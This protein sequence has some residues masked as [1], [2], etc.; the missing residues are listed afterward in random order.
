MAELLNVE[1]RETRGKRNSRRLRG[2]GK[3]PA[4]LYG[5]GKETISLSVSAEQLDAAV[6]HGARLVDLTGP[7]TQQAFIREVQWDVWG[8]HIIHADFT[9]ISSDERV[10]VEVALEIRGEAPGVR[11]GG[12]VEQPLHQ[13][14][15]EC[16]VTEIPEKLV[17]SINQL[18]LDDSITAG[19]LE[20][21]GNATIMADPGTV[22]VQCVLPAAEPDE[23]DGEYGEAEPE[24]IGRKTEGD[25]EAE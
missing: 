22:V 20:L 7:V 5:H 6:G 3:I 15:I 16:L 8:T 24:V 25:E 1:L 10:Q 19:Q 14:E 11:E 17:V 2:S 23:E 4:I 18:N 12:V 9:R 21:P 13:I